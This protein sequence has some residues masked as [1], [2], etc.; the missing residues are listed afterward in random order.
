M[1]E[2]QRRV[3]RVIQPFLLA[4]REHVR[5]EPITNVVGEGTKDVPGFEMPAGGE[6][7]PLEADHRVAAPVGEPV[8]AGDDR[9]HLVAGGTGPCRFLEA[10]GGGD[11][12]LVGGEHEFRSGPASHGR[13]CQ[14]KQP[15]PPLT[16]GLQGLFAR[17][18]LHRVERLGRG[19]ECGARPARKGD[20]EVPGTPEI[21]LRLIPAA[22]FHRVLHLIHPLPLQRE[23][24]VPEGQH[25]ERRQGRILERQFTAVADGA[26][27]VGPPERLRDRLFLRAEVHRWPQP[28]FNR[29][30]AL[31]QLVEHVHR[32]LHVRQKDAALEDDAVD[33]EPPHRQPR[34]E[35]ELHQVLARGLPHG[36]AHAL[37]PAELHAPAVRVAQLL[38]E[39]T[40]HDDAAVRCWK[41]GDQ[42]AVIAPGDEAGDGAGGV[43]AKAV[44]HEPLARGVFVGVDS[45]RGPVEDADRFG[46][47][48]SPRWV[49]PFAVSA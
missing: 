11:D 44:R 30:G 45:G 15:S 17:E 18:H 43:A 16:F 24:G 29:V 22:F 47:V 32:V 48:G 8:I 39:V 42:H 23:A 20:A 28:E 7:Q 5:D 31:Q 21:A 2:P 1:E 49:T 34:L 40:E 9:P 26:E 14:G 37:A 46:H 27:L 4:F 33:V 36:F 25:A 41:G 13:I 3:R 38:G 19:H 12:E 6:R 35:A 10:P